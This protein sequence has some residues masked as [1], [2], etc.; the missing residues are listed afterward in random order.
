MLSR[1]VFDK[2]K[3]RYKFSIRYKGGAE[4][5]F[6]E[7]QKAFYIENAEEYIYFCD[8]IMSKWSKIPRGILCPHLLIAE[9][10]WK[11]EKELENKPEILALVR[12]MR[13]ANLRFGE[14]IS[15]K[16]EDLKLRRFYSPKIDP[17]EL[18][19][20][21][22]SAKTERLLES[23]IEEDGVIFKKRSGYYLAYIR[24]VI[25][26]MRVIDIRHFCKTQKLLLA[27]LNKKTD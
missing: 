16:A 5:T 12:L 26:G 3:G 15:L 4:G 20:P 17:N 19:L 6:Y 14:A 11:L 8:Q 2:Q 1:I 27:Y 25:P 23:L 9:N 18:P 13:E 10:I 21:P 22:V 24:K 7:I